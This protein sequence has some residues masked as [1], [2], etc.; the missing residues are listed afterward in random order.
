M[1]IRRLAVLCALLAC[2]ASVSAAPGA[3]SGKATAFNLKGTSIFCDAGDAEVV[4]LAA[5][6]LSEDLQK[7]GGKASRVY[8]SGGTAS[9]VFDGRT[10]PVRQGDPKGGNIIIIGTLEGNR[11]IAAMAQKG[12]IDV[13][14]IRGGWERYAIR[15][16]RNPFKGVGRALVIAGSDRRGAA[17]G[18]MDIS[19]RIGVSPWVWWADAP[20]RKD[21]PGLSSAGGGLSID[22]KEFD[23]KEP[24]VRYRGI[25][26]NDEDWGLLP[27]ASK[28]F[29]PAFGNIGPKTYEK[30]FQLL[31]RLRANY[32]VPAMHR[33][34]TA[35]N[36]VPEN[37]VLADRYGIVMGSTHCEPLLFNNASE[38]DKAT[39][40]PWNYESNKDR[41]LTVLDERVG[42]NC[43][44][45][46]VWTL[47]LR[48]LH[49][50]AMEGQTDLE[51]RKRLLEEAIADQR[52]ILRRHIPGPV[53]ALP[54]IFIPYKEVLDLY[55]RGMKVPDEVTIVWPDDNY[56]YL[57]QVSG[58]REQ[59]RSGRSGVYYHV[60]YHGRPHDYL[61]FSTTPPALMYEE[62][63]KVFR[64]GGD[65]LWV[66]NAG[67]IKMCEYSVDLFLRMAYDFSSFDEATV[68]EDHAMWLSSMFGEEFRESFSFIT[69]EFYRLAFSSKPEFMGWGE[70]WNRIGDKQ[71]K[72][73]DTD[74]SP[75][76]A[77]KRLL[78]YGRIAGMASEIMDR[79]PE[80]SKAAF[81]ELV[82]F[83]VQ[84]SSLM[85]RMHLKAQKARQFA[86]KGVSADEAISRS[87]EAYDAL[88]AL[89]EGYNG[90]LGGKWKGIAQLEHGST[91]N[92]FRKPEV[93]TE[94]LKP[95][96]PTEEELKG[97]YVEK[98]GVVSIPAAGFHR[99][100]E[101]GGVAVTVLDGL[102]F[103]GSSVRLGDPL[104]KAQNVKDRSSCVEYDFYTF[105]SGPVDVYT[106]MLPTF[107][108]W[109]R[110]EFGVEY[111]GLDPSDGFQRYGIIIDGHTLEVPSIPTAE[112]S[113]QWMKG[114]L[115]N[116]SVQKT[117]MY[118]PGPGRH[119]IKI[120]CADQGVILQKIVIDL[121]G[122]ERSLLGP[123]PTLY[124]EASGQ[125]D[126]VQ[127]RLGEGLA[128]ER[129][130]SSFNGRLSSFI[131]GPDSP[132][133]QLFEKENLGDKPSSWK[134][135]HAGKWL[136]A[137]SLAVE[138]TASA[139][140]EG[141]LR[142]VADR[143]VGMQ[144]ENGYLGCYKPG[145][146]FYDSDVLGWDVW[147]NS[148][149]IQ[150]LTEAWKATG[151]SRYLDA[152]C[153]IADLFYDCFV[154]RGRSI[155]DTGHH[156]GMVGTGSISPLADLYAVR[157]EPR[158]RR[159][160]EKCLQE[161]ES[162][163][164]LGL[165]EKTGAGMDVSLVGNGK[166]Y[167][168]LRNLTGIAKFCRIVPDGRLLKCCENAW[169][170]I[171][172]RH[173]N[174]CG[175]PWGGVHVHNEVFN[176][177]ECFSPYGVCETCS[178]MEWMRLSR[179]LLLLTGDGK[180][181]EEIEKTFYNAILGAMRDGGKEWVYY[182]RLN[183]EVFAGNEWSCCWSSGM[184]AM[185]EFAGMVLGISADTLFVN[186]YSAASDDFIEIRTKYP[187]D[188][189]VEILF[190]KDYD[191]CLALRRPNWAD[192]FNLWVKNKPA[193]TVQEERSYL[194]L[195]GPWKAGDSIVLDLPFDFR[196]I[197]Q[198]S[199][200]E[201][202][203]RYTTRLKKAP[204]TF[205]FLAKGP[206]VYAL[207]GIR[208]GI[209]APA[210]PEA[211]RS[212]AAGDIANRFGARPFCLFSP[213]APDPWRTVWFKLSE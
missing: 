29:D 68:C 9:L 114:V 128:A 200:Y 145:I 142:A 172:E 52:E 160:I 175:G 104:G 96:S 56:G 12:L 58:P 27:W 101:V 48:G 65:R 77:E 87:A 54:Q 83:P 140:L 37:R 176:R 161:M 55:N 156:S 154:V 91:A 182:T 95:V 18:A 21:V 144:E 8:F 189:K 7:A 84:G 155:A 81:Y 4:H 146:R 31:L 125:M 38:W 211:G 108:P 131:T 137:A 80:S 28:T 63:S 115:H 74:Y 67:D 97:L 198:T 82:W 49:D 76:E 102:G 57:K 42:T 35:F 207:P 105:G 212:E 16:V 171:R 177:Q 148:Y 134:G 149:M 187:L 89:T 39:M 98:D 191:G 88:V 158:Y 17:F 59:K 100:G 185:E 43:A 119:T 147:I 6:M 208:D 130:E 10:F 132:A 213:S 103:E 194:L 20:V 190:R 163:P 153:R 41:I 120:L 181:A 169:T 179:E 24:S 32:L 141:R 151:E 173:L 150:G 111:A 107:L 197:S 50:K 113:Q 30:V 168:M 157:R 44:Y 193:G 139:E 71:A 25:F 204:E 124:G 69:R 22:V 188:G 60:S 34:S 136:Y 73:S 199:R 164:G 1:L 85:N 112:Y 11:H 92:Y 90:L 46:N 174:P 152:A 127:V 183:G 205:A 109:A 117:A 78:D 45:E 70:E 159:L 3:D 162:T 93:D 209:D 210:T 192:S 122:M 75:A 23:S 13:E 178:S 143:L 126:P 64:T 106:Y 165:L 5:A 202:D 66:V 110:D 121:G 138:R 201:N 26:I 15:L 2:A 170:D 79:L 86:R 123:A 14:G 196:T 53:E 36:A 118:I 203:G 129:I 133:I 47:A 167:E 19:E 186:A 51:T 116:C 180:Y 184:I 61:W 40:G 33:R 72:V 195:R 62:L 166:I 206:L 99:K 94:A 135:E